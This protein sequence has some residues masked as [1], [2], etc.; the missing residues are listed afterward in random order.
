MTKLVSSVVGGVVSLFTG[1]DKPA[2]QAAPAV[3]APTPM[4][5][6]DDA[7]VQAAQQKSIAEIIGRQGRAS[8][9][10]TGNTPAGG[11]KLGP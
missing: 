8:T 1:G 9:I 10:L 5:N 2:P 6:P 7:A 4:P 11:A 3:A